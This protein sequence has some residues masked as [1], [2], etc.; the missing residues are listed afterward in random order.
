MS[1]PQPG[2]LSEFLQSPGNVTLLL[3]GLATAV[4]LSFPY[5]LLGAAMPLLATAAVEFVAC[6][7]VPDMSTF[8][9]WADQRRGLKGRDELALRV[10]GEIRKRCPNPHQ[11]RKYEEDHKAISQ[12]VASLLDLAPKKPG[13]LGLEDMDRIANVPSEYLSLHLSLL[14]MDERASAIDLREINR[15]LEQINGQIERPGDGS[16]IRQLERARD[17]YKALIARHQRM[18]SKRAA[19]EAA[20]VALPDQLA[21]I[22]QIVVGESTQHDGARLADAIASLRLR[23]DIESE[24]AE[25][26]SGA[27]PNPTMKKT[28]D[29]HGVRSLR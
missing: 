23:Q 26:L 24:I 14:V 22:Y 19:I 10:I 5:G 7:F 11:F 3:C 16:D 17:E 29:S 2:Y 15:K 9:R 20:V 18:L 25:D 28:T 27:I 8:R 12:Q 13:S 4:V 6:L 1:D 21:E